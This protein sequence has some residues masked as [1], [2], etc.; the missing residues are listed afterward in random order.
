MRFLNKASDKQALSMPSICVPVCT[1]ASRISPCES[2]EHGTWCLN[3]EHSLPGLSSFGMAL[4]S[5]ECDG[6]DAASRKEK[7]CFICTDFSMGIASF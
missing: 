3:G 4:S 2:L 1:A 5:Q 7:S 6:F